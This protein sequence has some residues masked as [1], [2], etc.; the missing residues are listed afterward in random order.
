MK[1]DDLDFADNLVLLSH[2]QQQIQE[3]TTS[4]SAVSA[5]VGL[6]THEGE[7]KILRYNTAYTNRIT[8]DGEASENVKTF[9]YFGSIIDKRGGFDCEILTH[10]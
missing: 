9:T 4:V 6:N 7:R 10:C 2:M 3:K 5:A 8:L 1:L